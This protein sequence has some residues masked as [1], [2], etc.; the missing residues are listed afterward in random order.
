MNFFNL[1]NSPK[2]LPPKEL[3]SKSVNEAISLFEKGEVLNLQNKLFEM[4][5]YINKPGMGYLVTEYPSKD[6]LSE[7]FS[8]CLRYDW[9]HDSDIREVWA[10]NGF[11]CIATYMT[12]DAKTKEDFFA[13]AFDMFL[14]L[15]YGRNS[16]KRKLSNI[17]ET[18]YLRCNPIFDANDYE[19]G[20]EYL[21][22]QFAF[23]CATI[24][25]PFVKSNN[26]ISPE[27]QP[28]YQSS[29]NDFILASIS[30]NDVLAKAKFIAKVIGSIL[31]DM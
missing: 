4:Y 9:M 7:C 23:F 19:Y 6:R 3:F 17:L 20:S 5:S 12:E 1:F 18:A 27:V 31:N 26:I 16:L 22:R 21:I 2:A 24:I 15:Y 25:S 29:K 13:A 11:Y 8:L 30:P 10:E 14:L 28:F